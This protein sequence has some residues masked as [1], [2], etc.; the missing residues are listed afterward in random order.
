MNKDVSDRTPKFE[1]RRS[2]RTTPLVSEEEAVVIYSGNRG[3]AL[4][5]LM[6]LSDTGVLVYL[7]DGDIEPSTEP[8]LSL[9]HKGKIFKIRSKLIRREHRL[10]GFEFV[11]TSTTQNQIRTKLLH[12]ERDWVRLDGNSPS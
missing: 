8:N 10:V 7:L 9:F 12:M 4:A 3:A 6:D 5:K 11:Y 1:N 2:E